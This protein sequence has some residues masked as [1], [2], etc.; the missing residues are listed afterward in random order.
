MERGN[1][2]GSRIMTY[3]KAM[4]RGNPEIEEI[5]RIL[6]TKHLSSVHVLD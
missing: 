5:F 2:K 3:L 4:L 6:K 1:G